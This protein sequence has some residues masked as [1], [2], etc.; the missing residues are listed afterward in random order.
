MI[1]SR[2]NVAS[3]LKRNLEK[4]DRRSA[5][6]SYYLE[7]ERTGNSRLV[8]SY[9]THTASKPG[10]G[11]ASALNALQDIWT[12]SIC[13]TGSKVAL[14]S[15][16]ISDL[17]EAAVHLR[18]WEFFEKIAADPHGLINSYIFEWL[19]KQVGDGKV[20][21]QNVKRGYV[22]IILDMRHSFQVE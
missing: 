12:T 18:E 14:T 1:V 22:V 21:F 5:Y 2:A 8:V 17:L 20:S 19:S 9:L 15:T 7:K 6:P 4:D 13:Q 3:F 11:Q 10:K 16:E